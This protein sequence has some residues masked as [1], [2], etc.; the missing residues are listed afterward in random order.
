MKRSKFS[1][2]QIAY[3]LKQAELGTKVEEVCRKVGI[4][5]AT[6]YNW[7]QQIRWVSAERAAQVEAA[8]RGEQHVEAPGC[9]FELGQGDVAGRAFKKALKPSRKREIADRLMMSYGASERRVCM[10]LKLSRTVYRYRSRARDSS[11]LMS[12]I[13][14]IAKT[15]VHYGYRRLHVLL[16][17]AGFKDNHKR[18][19]RLYREQGLSLRL[20]RPRRNKAAQSRQPLGTATHVNRVWG[21]DFVA[22]N[23]F[24]G[25]KLR[26]LTAVDC[27]TRESLAIHVVARV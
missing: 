13:K 19:Y 7:K 15:R 24:D 2:E 1:E 26:M 5:E 16:K 14:E 27:F 4:S 17:R 3:A 20:K 10:A 9:G 12:R 22:D 23:L 25:R 8:R 6:F 21:M 18:V 11:V